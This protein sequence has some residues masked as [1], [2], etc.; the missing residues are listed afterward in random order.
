VAD[1]VTL[2][3]LDDRVDDRLAAGSTR[4]EHRELERDAHPLLD[5]PLTT[6]REHGVERLAVGDDLDAASVVATGPRLRD[7]RPAVRHRE[8]LDAGLVARDDVRGPG[9][10]SAANVSRATSL[11]CATRSARAEGGPGRRRLEGRERAASTSSWSSVTTSTDFGERAAQ[12]GR[13]RPRAGAAPAVTAGSSSRSAST[14]R[15][16]PR[17]I[18]ARWVMRAS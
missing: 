16:T 3:R 2:H 17:S 12:P 10:P 9:S 14:V 1:A 13:R 11:S 6:A 5:D 4:D 15:C 7:E 18:A 8:L